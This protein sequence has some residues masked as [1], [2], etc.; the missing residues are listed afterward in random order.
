MNSNRN[1]QKKTKSIEL[2]NNIQK[3]QKLIKEGRL[4]IT[5][6]SQEKHI[7]EIISIKT[8]PWKLISLSNI[9]PEA[10]AIVSAIAHLHA[11]DMQ[12]QNYGQKEISIKE[13]QKHLFDHLSETLNS[14]AGK[15]EWEKKTID[16]LSNSISNQIDKQGRTKFRKTVENQA[17][18]LVKF[19]QDYRFSIFKQ[20]K[21]LGGLK[22]NIGGQREIT[23]TTISGIKRMALYADTQLIPDPVY[24]LLSAETLYLNNYFTSFM[25]Q[26]FYLNKLS[27]LVKKDIENPPIFVFPSFENE[28]EEQDPYTQNGIWDLVISV[29]N[30][31]AQTEFLRIEEIFKWINE[32][33]ER[34]LSISATK[35]LLVPPGKA[36]GE[37]KDPTQAI[38]EY[39][40]EI[41]IT[42]DKVAFQT[43][44]KMPKEEIALKLI[45][46][47]LAK[48]FHLLE[49]SEEIDSQPMLVLPAH[50]HYFKLASQARE[51]T[52]IRNNVISQDSFL[53]LQALQ[54]ET[55]NWLGD[56][57]ME[58]LAE[59]LFNQEN[60][61][62][63]HDLSQYTKQLSSSG[64]Q[65]IDRTVKEVSHGIRHMIQEH[66]KN[67]NQIRE[68]YRTKYLT[69]ATR[70]GVSILG[71]I[72]A[73]F[74]PMLSSFG[75]APPLF[76][77]IPMLKGF[78]SDGIQHYS[79]VKKTRKSMLGVFAQVH[80]KK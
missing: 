60:Q 30:N 42:R 70:G 52:L 15:A 77:S 62:F 23:E 20:A 65:D 40:K 19:Y 9:S 61:K 12:R 56:I 16:D 1:D 6:P 21:S 71:G 55:L 75:A 32:N 22:L 54:H 72:G 28:L 46:E 39:L 79:E 48:Q 5:D 74:L 10:R 50:W 68:K 24:P 36:P 18:N 4:R 17:N 49:N 63:R 53:H 34:F 45:I 37:I 69:T 47:R 31:A 78:I 58:S 14:I 76:T 11:E 26:A 67:M 8:E 73:M 27:A 51:N 13:S 41:Q 66:N 64:I 57:P 59:M 25:R 7:H 44:S 35:Q 80:N 2:T 29:I 38:Q 33:P 43:I 3:V